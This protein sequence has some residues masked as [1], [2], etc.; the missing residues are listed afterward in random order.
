MVISKK[1][2]ILVSWL[3]LAL[4]ALPAVTGCGGSG[5]GTLSVLATKVSGTGDIAGSASWTHQPGHS[6]I[7]NF[8]VLVDKSVVPE[9]VLTDIQQADVSVKVNGVTTPFTWARASSGISADL[10]FI[11][12]TT[13]SMGGEIMGVRNSID[14]FATNINTRIN[15][16]FGLVT[17]GDAFS[18]KRASGSSF[19]Y[20]AGAYEPPSF[21]SSERPYQNL[22]S[23]SDFKNLLN[24]LTAT[25][26]AGTPEN[27]LGAINWAKDHLSFTGTVRHWILMTD[28][29]A[30]THDS[31]SDGIVDPFIPPNPADLLASL[32]G[33][34]HTISPTSPGSPYDVKGLSTE[35]GGVWIQMP[36]S[37]NVD[38]NTLGIDTAVSYPYTLTISSIDSAGTYVIEITI[39]KGGK[40][41]VITYNVVLS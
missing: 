9:E 31:H 20:G 32:T 40:T 6:L 7:G 8:P 33:T 5:G 15:A 10:I 17:Y 1:T 35:T 38:L 23:L 12:D 14:T 4:F 21:D 39:T 37:G 30:Y 26:G 29:P 24:E 19:T 18:T 16:R 3:L 11:V 22:S 34:V 27:P 28:A 13:G 36:A 2:R 25:G 41:G